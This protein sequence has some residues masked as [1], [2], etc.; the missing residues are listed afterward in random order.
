MSILKRPGWHNIINE[1]ADAKAFGLT[2]KQKRVEQGTAYRV[3]RMLLAD[4]LKTNGLIPKEARTVTAAEVNNIIAGLGDDAVTQDVLGAWEQYADQQLGSNATAEVQ[5]QVDAVAQE[6]E[7]ASQGQLATGAREAG[8]HTSRFIQDMQD[9][10][11]NVDEFL[12]VTH[13]PKGYRHLEPSGMGMDTDHQY[14][15]QTGAGKAIRVLSKA[16]LRSKADLRSSQVVFQDGSEEYNISFDQN[17]NSKSQSVLYTGENEESSKDCGCPAD[18]DCEHMQTHY[19]SDVY[20]PES[21]KLSLKKQT[22]LAEQARVQRY[23]HMMRME[24]RYM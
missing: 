10:I 15:N 24:Q 22:V 18:E 12:A 7:D 21:H 2:A 20:M 14:V 13:F 3:V 11:K 4:F 16:P 8:G 5:Q 17:G 19:S 23:Q 1:M 9:K 6:I